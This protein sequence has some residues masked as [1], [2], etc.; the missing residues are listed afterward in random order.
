MGEKE[1]KGKMEPGGRKEHESAK[2]GLPS[3]QRLCAVVHELAHHIPSP[4]FPDGTDDATVAG[5]YTQIY[6]RL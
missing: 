4:V 6:M 3:H 1:R 2:K 5:V